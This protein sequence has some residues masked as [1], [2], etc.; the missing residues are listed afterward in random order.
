MK[1]FTKSV[2]SASVATVMMGSATIAQ[3][4]ESVNVAFFF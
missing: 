1:K 2:V 3:A 4:A